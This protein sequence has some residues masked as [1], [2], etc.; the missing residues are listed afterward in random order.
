MNTYVRYGN[1]IDYHSYLR[2]SLAL[3]LQVSTCVPAGLQSEERLK[4]SLYKLKSLMTANPSFPAP[5][6][7][8]ESGSSWPRWLGPS[9]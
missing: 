4:G 7:S 6:S 5:V 3:A 8:G 9:D 1:W 2:T